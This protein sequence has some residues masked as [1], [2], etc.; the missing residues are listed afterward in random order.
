MKKRLLVF[1]I[2]GIL[3]LNITG[4]KNDKT[5]DQNSNNTNSNVSENENDTR[6]VL[7]LED[8]RNNP[9]SINFEEDSLLNFK[10][11]NIDNIKLNERESS[12]YNNEKELEFFV[13]YI[14]ENL[15][16]KRSRG[17]GGNAKIA[18]NTIK[19]AYDLCV[20]SGFDVDY[21][22]TEYDDEVKLVI[23]IKK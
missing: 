12:L 6:E 3:V 15:N 23:K 18:I 17:V 1:L 20:K 10:S 11:I 19:Q 16:R 13:K 14:K 8:Y 5:I 9:V 21:K 4:C 2:M 7:K 22:E